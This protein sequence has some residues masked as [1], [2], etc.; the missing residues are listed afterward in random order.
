MA[1][2][3]SRFDVAAPFLA[4]ALLLFLGPFAL[5]AVISRLA[6]EYRRWA[7]QQAL[8]ERA[9][10]CEAKMSAPPLIIDP[11]QLAQNAI[12]AVDASQ[13]LIIFLAPVVGLFILHN[14]LGTAIAVLYVA[15]LVVTLAGFLAFTFLGPIDRYPS[16]GFWI[17]TPV[18]VLGIL[19]TLA[20]AGTAALIGP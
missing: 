12:W 11:D 10:E 16:W 3:T 2:A 15:S 9:A 18:T 4:S 19:A 20:A 1:F 6:G 17:F 8:P 5:L 13:I 14:H 7:S